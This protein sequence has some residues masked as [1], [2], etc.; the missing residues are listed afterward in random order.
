[1]KK[2]LFSVLFL[3][4]CLAVPL[5]AAALETIENVTLVKADLNDGAGFKVK[6]EL[7]LRLYQGIM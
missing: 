1:M 5:P 2:R 6:P 3:S 4:R 7:H